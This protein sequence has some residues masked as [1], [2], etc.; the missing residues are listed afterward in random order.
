M[1]IIDSKRINVYPVDN[2]ETLLNRIAYTF[3][4]MPN[5]I[6][7]KTNYDVAE[8][9]NEE[10]CELEIEILKNYYTKHI[11][12]NINNDFG[13]IITEFAIL[14]DKEKLSEKFPLTLEHMIYELIFYM[15]DYEAHKRN[16]NYSI[17]DYSIV[18]TRNS[19]KEQQEFIFLGL[20]SLFEK[21][22]I[23]DEKHFSDEF[24]IYLK[25]F[26]N[27]INKFNCDVN[28]ELKN[29][30]NID[31]LANTITLSE[32]FVT[33]IEYQFNLKIKYNLMELFNRFRVNNDYVI[34]KYQEY[35]KC[36][37]Q[38]NYEN[39]KRIEY[40]YK[41]GTLSFS[42]MRDNNTIY[43]IQVLKKGNELNTKRYK[44]KIIT[45]AESNIPYNYTVHIQTEVNECTLNT[46]E[47]LLGYSIVKNEIITLLT[48][49]TKTMYRVNLLTPQEKKEFNFKM[50][51]YKAISIR[52]NYKI[53]NYTIID[54]LFTDFIFNTPQWRYFININD[55]RHKKDK[56]ASKKNQ[57][58][59]Y[60]NHHDI[61]STVN[62]TKKFISFLHQK[63]KSL[64]NDKIVNI[65]GFDIGQ[66]YIKISI[67]IKNSKN[68]ERHFRW[69]FTKLFSDYK[70]NE[71]KLYI[72]YKSYLLPDEY[73]K[74]TKLLYK[75]NKKT[76][77]NETL[78]NIEPQLYVANY[79]LH[80]G[81][82]RKPIIIND[83]K[84]RRMYIKQ[85]FFNNEG[86]DDD[87][88]DSDEDDRKGS[89]DDDRKGSDDDRKGSDD[90]DRKGSDDDGGSSDDEKKGS[91]DEKYNFYEMLFPK[92]KIII[93][94]T[95]GNPVIINP[96]YYVAGGESMIYKYPGISEN[97][98]A[99]KSIF[100]YIPC[101]YTTPQVGI[102]GSLYDIYMRDDTKTR[103]ENN[104]NYI[105]KNAE[106]IL[107]QS[108]DMPKRG[109]LPS[110][111]Q[112]IFDQDHH[113]YNKV[114]IP[115]SPNS[116]L[117]CLETAVR[118]VPQNEEYVINIRRKLHKSIHIETVLQENPDVNKD[119][120]I[121]VLNTVDEFLDVNIYISLLEYYYECNIHLI[122]SV[123][124]KKSKNFS[125][126]SIFV[127][128][129]NIK[130]TYYKNYKYSN[131][132]FIYVHNKGKK[133][134]NYLEYNHYELIGVNTPRNSDNFPLI[135]VISKQI[136]D[137]TPKKQFIFQDE[138]LITAVTEYY[139]YFYID[140]LVNYQEFKPS[141]N[142]ELTHQYIDLY[143]K[144]RGLY[145]K[146]PDNA[147]IFFYTL[148]P[149]SPYNL[150]YQEKEYS[151][152]N[153]FTQS[154]ASVFKFIKDTQIVIQE[155]VKEI[156][157]D[158]TRYGL[159]GTY[160]NINIYIPSVNCGDMDS[161][162]NFL[163]NLKTITYLEIPEFTMTIQEDSELKIYNHKQMIIKKIL[164]LTYERFSIYLYLN[165]IK[166]QDNFIELFKNFYIDFFNKNYYINNN[167]DY[168]I[169]L[170]TNEI[171]GLI[172][173]SNLIVI[174]NKVLLQL[175]KH[176]SML[177]T[178]NISI[179]EYPYKQRI[180]FSNAKHF[181]K[182]VENEII[183]ESES[184]FNIWYTNKI[185]SLSYNI[186][187]DEIQIDKN[188][189]FI[190]FN[191]NQGDV[192]Y[193]YLATKYYYG[194]IE[195][196]EKHNEKDSILESKDDAIERIKNHIIKSYIQP[197]DIK[198]VY[199][200]IYSYDLVNKTIKLIT[201]EQVKSVHLIFLTYLYNNRDILLWM[202]KI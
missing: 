177:Y 155:K 123:D 3:N 88:E 151:D 83:A 64:V 163:S 85:T 14:Y 148:P 60:Y 32:F 109:Y 54:S 167:V 198:D 166:I 202:K 112:K 9:I 111:M 126:D 55:N 58:K 160:E 53:S 196:E 121:H 144:V 146:T 165:K 65:P 145:I 134:T 40:N 31:L 176:L 125:I 116:I 99:N 11:Q 87:G 94:D 25:K 153:I 81:G 13:T 180:M 37:T 188:S 15:D 70:T 186:I 161:S 159:H 117:W 43:I 133:A 97:K 63:P 16:I 115:I 90:D 136:T 106:H 8:C 137:S 39:F 118:G 199:V 98:L 108:G 89:D 194:N 173:K 110:S 56:K 21:L 157:N 128:P 127:L 162:D 61:E 139:K 122:S 6:N 84:Q 164:D 142:Y 50:Q 47:K 17:I 72:I 96:Q 170:I 76:E 22:N 95:D 193:K 179:F 192:V 129:S 75:K 178:N 102:A 190:Y 41:I 152:G 182:K 48:N 38:F 154:Y 5:N 2:K 91:D 27:D 30:K 34:V 135:C 197:I 57:L 92:K 24:N 86:S 187:Y 52:G 131:N 7:I 51:N 82:V 73:K 28:T 104:P 147:I 69:I 141:K 124:I 169:N 23:R 200:T 12:D 74:L 101:T 100:P 35:F 130:S 119:E 10:K 1:L 120:L 20:V 156:F 68:I 77:I 66:N 184:V 107:R 29:L 93:N 168:T 195:D 46:Q 149:M 33:K 175:S 42:P 172:N 59:A 103:N 138:K 171:V 143:G 19:T 44:Y 113:K 201:S 49:F 62:I 174:T 105:S 181:F 158:A 45:I 78:E 79:S 189:Y 132:I 183:M 36:Y 185:K 80:C 140:K 26:I 18:Y 191:F 67:D 4:V 150:P 114:S 71:E